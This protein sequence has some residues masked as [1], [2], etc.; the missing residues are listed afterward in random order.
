MRILKS[1]FLF[2]IAIVLVAVAAV[3]V[4]P[5]EKIAQA[6]FAK[7][8]DATGRKITASGDVSI[9]LFPVLGVSISG[10]EMANADWS[11]L[12]P[13]VS[14]EQLNVGVKT[15]PLLQKRIEV[16]QLELIAPK[17]ILEIASNGTGN[18]VFNAKA[19]ND[20]ASTANNTTPSATTT[21][22]SV[23]DVT[24]S[25][26]TIKNGDLR[27][28]DHAAASDYQLS[29]LNLTL[30]W[31]TLAADV[32]ASLSAQFNG[33]PISVTL[34]STS[35]MDLINGKSATV[36]LS[37]DLSGSQIKYDGTVSMAPNATG[38]LNADI[39]NIPALLSL[40]GLSGVALPDFI[41]NSAKVKTDI[42]VSENRISLPNLSV[43]LTKNAI[44][45]SLDIALAAKATVSGS[46]NIGDFDMRSAGGADQGTA[47]SKTSASTSTGWSTAPIDVS[48]LGALNADIALTAR[49]LKLDA[50]STQAISG[51]IALSDSRATVTL[52]DVAAY[53]GNIKGEVILN[54]RKGL[55]SSADLRATQIAMKPLLTEMA[56]I[57]K[58]GGRADVSL[59]Y[60]SNGNSLDALIKNL[61]GQGAISFAQ[62]HFDGVDMDKLMRSGDV[63][64]GTTVFD[65]LNAS[66]SIK[67]GVVTNKDLKLSLPNFATFGEGQIN[68]GGQ[69]I[70]Y[71]LSPKALK[72]RDGKGLS[73][74]VRIKGP[75]SGP[76]IIPDLEAA[77]NQN[78]EAEKAK[79]EAKVKAAVEAEKKKIEEKAKKKVEKALGVEVQKG[80]KV[81]DA[82]K[83]KIEDEAKKGV[84]KL[85]GKK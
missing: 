68:L 11:T 53:D 3:F 48:A 34:A 80:Q 83:K 31:P 77:V 82:V 41:G 70:D 61:S 35:P 44:S 26:V 74:P 33:Q 12:G 59:S 25:T 38:S 1:L 24:L 78:L 27:F 30:D 85:L 22:T 79:A 19:P 45:A 42:S 29:A 47:G 46:V 17:L 76:K 65:D 20:A 51:R 37:A 63:G 49:S 8:E 67:E 57:T 23:P 21:P 84:L 9:R 50:L 13:M 81:E 14:A 28:V 60:L 40:A 62:G 32:S 15:G 36:D 2:V 54:G 58:F 75:W 39:P 52:N 4:I 69:T 64:S 7:I 43:G 18:W 73:I 66:F 56:E 10:V 55:S 6:A 71:L 72:A 16:S 5:K